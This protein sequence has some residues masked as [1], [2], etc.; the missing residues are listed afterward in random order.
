VTGRHALRQMR[1]VHAAVG[2]TAIA[3][4]ATALA[5]VATSAHVSSSQRSNSGLAVRLSSGR[6]GYGRDV[7][8]TGRAPAAEAGQTVSL[9]YAS[10]PAESRTWR[11]LATTQVRASGRFRLAAPLRRTGVVRAVGSWQPGAQ[12]ASALNGVSAAGDASVTAT[13]VPE[14]VLVDA[15]LRIPAQALAVYGGG[16][17][18]VRGFLLPRAPGRRVRLQALRDGRWQTV[19]SGQT[20]RHGGFVLRYSANGIGREPLRVEFAG[21]RANGPTRAAAGSV[22]VFT[23]SVASWYDDGG[24]T[25]CGFHAYYGVAN[26]SLPCGTRVAFRYNGR[27][28][29]AVVDDR[30]PFVAGREWDLNQNLAAALGFGGVGTVWSSQ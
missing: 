18:R 14:R 10:G 17:V 21:D 20:M 12:Q 11:T 25:A 24:N 26:R 4:P 3:I 16:A 15:R 30:G 29:D 22:T 9:Q 23:E 8:L 13:S 6:I 7:I 28:V 1:R 27:T 2:A 5:D 19:G